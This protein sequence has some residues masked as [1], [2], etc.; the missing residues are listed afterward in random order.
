MIP[1]NIVNEYEQLKNEVLAHN[2][3]YFVLANPVISDE[4]YDKL[5]K[6]LVE[7]ES[8][9]PQIK[10]PDS[11]SFRVGSAAVSGFAKIPH[12][13]PM[14]S[15]DNTYNDEDIKAFNDRVLKGLDGQS[16]EYL[17][18]LKIDGVS[19]SLSYEKGILV[20]ALTRGDGIAG[21]DVTINIKTLHSIPLKLNADIDLQVRGEVYMPNREFE[22]INNE[23]DALG[24]AIFANPRNATAGTLKLLDSMEVAKRHLSSFMYYIIDPSALKIETQLQALEYLDKIGFSVNKEYMLAKSIDSVTEY[25]RKWD[26]Q[27]KTLPYETDGIVVK[28]NSFTKQQILGQ[29]I[30]SPR[31]AIAY[32]YTSEKKITRIIKINLQVGS[33]GI[34]TPVAELEPVQLEGTTVKRASLHNFEYIAERDIMENDYVLVEKAGGIIPQVIRSIPEKRSGQEKKVIFPQSCPVCGHPTGKLSPQEVAVRCLNPLCPEKT[35]RS[36]ENFVS[37]DAMNIDGM[38]PKIIERLAQAGYIKDISD[39]YYL[40]ELKIASLGS[41]IGI[42]TISNLMDQIEKSKNSSLE[43][44]LCGIGIPLVGKKTARDLAIHFKDLRI[45][46]KSSIHELT[47]LE[48][49]GEDMAR[50]I[51]SFFSSQASFVLLEKLEKAG[52]NFIYKQEKVSDILKDIIVSV[53][54]ELLRFKRKEFEKYVHERGGIFSDNLTKKTK[55]LVI[56][57]NPSSKA[58]KAK[59]WMIPSMSEEEFFEKYR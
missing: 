1:K 23:R 2:Y 51:L 29:T 41:G 10:S 18:E 33:T 39:I 9:Y 7:I 53:T 24:L 20:Q 19:I 27:R 46:A 31:W 59:S 16:P 40:D 49:I 14:L 42:K 55:I 36:I 47:S 3:K 6:R 5:F 12:S 38:G 22:R 8:L 44:L 30:R 54:G 17:C 48:G 28:V 52:V 37:K 35:I 56:G 43:R 32:K 45:I 34:I 50:S 57:Q 25:W 11:P 21:E 15:L 4:E 26:T 58:E 13:I